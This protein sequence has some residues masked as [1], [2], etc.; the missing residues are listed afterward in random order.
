VEGSDASSSTDGS[1]SRV[2]AEDDAGKGLGET[3]EGAVT[4]FFLRMR[5][6]FACVDV[7]S[8]ADAVSLAAFDFDFNLEGGGGAS[9]GSSGRPCAGRQLHLCFTILK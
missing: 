1:Q 2:T 7:A 8:G 9:L 6:G 4:V 5:F 3:L